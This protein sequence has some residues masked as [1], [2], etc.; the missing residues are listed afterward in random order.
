MSA[1][2][3]YHVDGPDGAPVLV[4]G[5]SLGTDLRMWEP[6]LPALSRHFR[7]VRYDHRGHGSSEVPAGPYSLADLAGD[8][9][10][11]L[12]HLGVGRAHLGGLSL[13]GMVAMWLAAHAPARVDRVVLFCT[14]AYLP[15]PQ[16]WLD[17]AATV[18]DGGTAAV[19]DAVTARWFTP[20][21]ATARPDVLAAHRAM[22]VSQ[23]RAGYA[24]CCEAVA[25][26]DLRDA[27]PA[28]EAP[29]LVV[30]G[31]NDLA[32]PEPHARTIAER[33]GPAARVELVD[34]AHLAT[35]ENPEVCS[36]LIVK[37]LTS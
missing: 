9:L 12:D 10:A 24:A 32:T 1:G 18:R 30:A 19:V 15:P 27:L 35:V 23:P 22:M 28:V 11:L 16:G 3:G 21:F 31:R 2:L 29:T 6:Q 13:G 7:V 25:G 36:E 14:S 34:G 26:M 33:I 4:L 17:R 5:S 20:A 8:V 37:H